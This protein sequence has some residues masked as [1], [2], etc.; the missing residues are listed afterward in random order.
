MREKGGKT[1]CGNREFGR[2]TRSLSSDDT[3]RAFSFLD[4][5]YSCFLVYD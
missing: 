1:K 2:W 3:M 5:G 4:V